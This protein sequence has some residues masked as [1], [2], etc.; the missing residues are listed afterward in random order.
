M[1]TATTDWVV[2]VHRG[3]RII[4]VRYPEAPTLESLDRYEAE[5][6]QAIL[7]MNG[8]WHCL[9]D[10][11]A[12]PVLDATMSN[13][14]AELIV[15]ARQHGMTHAARVVRRGSMATLQA[16]QLLRESGAEEERHIYLSREEAFAALLTLAAAS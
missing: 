13:R 15:W 14:I 4:E 10:Q 7:S 11:R 6:R 1:A 16:K 5:V 2:I 12:M 3:E 8:P 9:V